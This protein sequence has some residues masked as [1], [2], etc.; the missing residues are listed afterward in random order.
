MRNRNQT[1]DTYG[2]LAKYV[3]DG[4]MEA[5]RVYINLPG[6]QTPLFLEPPS[7]ESQKVSV[8]QHLHRF[9]RI[10]LR[11]KNPPNCNLIRKPNFKIRITGHVLEQTFSSW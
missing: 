9:G 8:A 7:P 5:M 2:T 10:F 6:K 1:A 4:S 11:T 3:P